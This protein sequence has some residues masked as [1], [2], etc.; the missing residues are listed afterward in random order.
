[1]AAITEA[2]SIACARTVVSEDNELFLGELSMTYLYAAPENV[3]LL[4]F[5]VQI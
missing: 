2:I 3:S 4:I 1:M 5:H